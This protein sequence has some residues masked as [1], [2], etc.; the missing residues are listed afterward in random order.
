MDNLTHSL[1][2][3]VLGQAGLKRRT[4]LAMPALILAANLPDIDA[5]CVIY[6]VESLAMRRGITHGPIALIVLPAILAAILLAFDRWQVRRDARP[7][8]RAPMRPGW[9]LA[10]CYIGTLT[11]PAFDWLNSYGI[12]LLEPFSQRWFYGD[13]LFIIDPWLLA[14]L[15]VGI[16]LS[17]NR[18]KAGE[19]KWAR[20]AWAAIA[21]ALAYVALNIVVSRVATTSVLR[22]N[23]YPKLAVANA[24][25]GAFWRRDVLWRTESG[26]GSVPFSLF[27]SGV[28]AG[29]RRET[30]T[31]MDDPR[32]AARAGNNPSARAFLFWSRMP[33]ADLRRDTVVLTD[34]RFMRGPTRGNFIVEL[35][36]K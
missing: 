1:I 8:G 31:N 36:P 27:G 34:Q 19:D 23:P 33:V 15:G 3:A 26:Y 35:K 25:P 12:R 7:A 6:G 13:A 18:E 11:H 29:E 20:P 24:V 32:I 5:P 4:G 21:G 10:L 17:W 2:G 16:W 22:D 30:R 9:L 28:R 14:M